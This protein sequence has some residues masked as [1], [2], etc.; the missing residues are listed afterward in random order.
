MK[1]FQGPLVAEALAVVGI[2][3]TA[4]VLCVGAIS[5]GTVPVPGYALLILG[6][7]SIPIA[8]AII[9]PKLFNWRS[10]VCVAFGFAVYFAT[11]SLLIS[12]RAVCQLIQGT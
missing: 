8:T 7:A 11:L 6:S 3:A 9:S 4:G 12:P 1:I 2:A 5:S 10:I